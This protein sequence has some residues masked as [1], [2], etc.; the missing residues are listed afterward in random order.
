MDIHLLHNPKNTKPLSTVY[1]VIS[2]DEEGNEGICAGPAPFSPFTAYISGNL[3]I[4]RT[5]FTN[6]LTAEG[7]RLVLRSYTKSNDLEVR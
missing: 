2:Q 5:M 7:K 4:A 3:E 6:A 1:I